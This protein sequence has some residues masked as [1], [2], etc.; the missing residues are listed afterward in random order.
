MRSLLRQYGLNRRQIRSIVMLIAPFLKLKEN[1]VL[2]FVFETTLDNLS[3]LTRW[4]FPL[5]QL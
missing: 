5:F 4:F 3:K 2:V 1:S